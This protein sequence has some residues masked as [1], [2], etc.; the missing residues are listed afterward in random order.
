MKSSLDVVGGP[1]PAISG[2][3]AQLTA[4]RHGRPVQ[5]TNTQRTT[6]SQRRA[7]ARLGAAASSTPMTRQDLIAQRSVRNWNVQDGQP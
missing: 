3:R 6:L 7:A 5:T 4:L 2:H 1:A